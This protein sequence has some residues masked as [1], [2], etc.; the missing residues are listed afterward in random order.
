[1][2]CKYCGAKVGEYDK[3]CPKCGRQT[4]GQPEK[5]ILVQKY[6]PNAEF[7]SK[8][9]ENRKWGILA[10]I[11]T[12]VF[13]PL[14]LLFSIIG[15]ISYRDKNDPYHGSN[16]AK[17]IVALILSGIA[18]AIIIWSISVVTRVG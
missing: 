4:E 17:C 18:T 11:F 5:L 14:G 6:D 8:R 1:M 7:N 2:Y 12:F 13:F 10:M 9:T 16:L 3:Y 15:L